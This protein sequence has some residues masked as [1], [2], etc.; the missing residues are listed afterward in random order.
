MLHESE[1]VFSP[2]TNINFIFF[3]LKWCSLSILSVS[4]QMQLRS[5]VACEMY[6][7][8]HFLARKEL[9]DF[10][11]LLLQ[12]VLRDIL[13]KFLPDDIHARCSGRIR[14]KFPL[15]FLFPW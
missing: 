10:F 1:T 7:D 8:F 14:G 11:M 4:V 12:A 15:H 6:K 9:P 2:T 3:P 5:R 13:N